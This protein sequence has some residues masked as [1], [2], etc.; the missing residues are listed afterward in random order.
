MLLTAGVI[1]HSIIS[2]R[3]GDVIPFI[4]SFRHPGPLIYG[5][6]AVLGITPCLGFACI[7]LPLSPQEF[8]IGAP[9]PIPCH[10]IPA[11]S[12]MQAGSLATSMHAPCHSNRMLFACRSSVL[13]RLSMRPHMADL[14][15]VFVLC[16]MH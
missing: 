5:I 12:A 4:R 16:Y 1:C 15:H 9:P 8:A 7:R 6:V 3:L 2:P 11:L 13:D 10:L 14:F